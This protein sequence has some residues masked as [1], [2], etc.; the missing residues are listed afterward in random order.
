MVCLCKKNSQKN[1]KCPKLLKKIHLVFIS[2]M[3]EAVLKFNN[4]L[5]NAKFITCSL[6][7]TTINISLVCHF[8]EALLA[9]GSQEHYKSNFDLKKIP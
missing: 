4:V 1:V 2:E 3:C 6:K 5:N 8:F 7:Y 9:N